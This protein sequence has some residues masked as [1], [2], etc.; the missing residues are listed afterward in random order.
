MLM[1]MMEV[2][3]R[4]RV[5]V[6]RSGFRVRHLGTGIGVWC[7]YCTVHRSGESVCHRIR[8]FEKRF[9]EGQHESHVTCCV[10]HNSQHHKYCTGVR[11][12]YLYMTFYTHDMN[13]QYYV[14]YSEYASTW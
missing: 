11:S 6:Y 2:Y 12:T 9:V 5:C 10:S 7:L 8:E 14:I 4:V 1:L 13:I 3:I